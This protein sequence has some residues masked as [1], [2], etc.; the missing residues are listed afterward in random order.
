MGVDFD[1]LVNKVCL[2]TFGEVAQ[3]T[4]AV[5][6]R[7]LSGAPF[8]LDGVFDEAWRDL[9]IGSGL[10]GRATDFSTT[11]P[12]FGTRLA[13]FPTGLRLSVSNLCLARK[14]V[15]LPPSC[16]PSPRMELPC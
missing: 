5:T 16:R 10:L 7:P 2:D 9:K 13:L 4:G 12:C 11:G 14:C 3:G 1:G 6:Y 15:P 8:A